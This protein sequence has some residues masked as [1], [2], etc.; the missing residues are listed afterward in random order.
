MFAQIG[1]LRG[2][3]SAPISDKLRS[4]VKYRGVE[5]SEP[6][7]VFCD[8]GGS[9][10]CTDTHPI[11]GVVANR[12]FDYP[13]TLKGLCAFAAHR[14]GLPTLR[15]AAAAT[16]YLQRANQGH[17]PTDTERDYL[18][19]YPGFQQAYG[20]PIEIPEPGTP[21][22]VMCAEPSGADARSGAVS[23]AQQITGVD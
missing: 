7:L 18:V 22:W 8:K 14:R 9:G 3:R 16:P 2:G 17:R 23:V 6:A 5:L 12:P 15:S 10:T 1:L 20:L 21:G 11:R 4:L 19:D 13:L